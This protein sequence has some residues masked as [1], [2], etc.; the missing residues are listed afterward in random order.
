MPINESKMIWKNGEMIP[1]ADA[2]THVLSHALH[3]GTAV[4]EGI[5]VYETPN[6][7]MAFRLNDHIKRMADSAR[8]Y[9]M[10]FK[11]ETEQ[12]VE[13]CRE[14]VKVNG[15]TSAYLRPIAYFGYG[16]IGVLPDEATPL[17]LVIA[18]FSWGAYLGEEGKANGVDVCI[19]SWNRVAPNTIP[20]A[21]K[22][23]G[24]YLSG[25]LVGK[26]A[27]NR[28][29]DEGIAL[30]TNGLLSEGAGE[31]IFVVKD[32]RI[33]TPPASSSIM[34]GITRDTILTL[35]R[36]RGFEVVEQDIPRELL[37]LADELFL[38]GTA[39]EIT[40]V[41]SVDGIAMKAGSPGP[42]TQVISDVFFGLFD[43]TT[44]DRHGWLQPINDLDTAT[45]NI[46]EIDNAALA[47]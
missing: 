21:A 11:W 9:Q 37:Y 46:V 14:L 26:E 47:G 27:H 31:N 28:G 6:G 16:S 29:F 44:I 34:L 42:I 8:I 20:A 4:F 41:R 17:D 30:G 15:L 3:Y 19:S 23:A 39:A 40:P 35:A 36:E 10:P 38:S 5:R 12:L 24:N 13:A 32:G 45:D 18:A 2:T 22:A 7:P 1:W 25:Y 43:G 33:I